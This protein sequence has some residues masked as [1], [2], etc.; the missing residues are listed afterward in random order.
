[1]LYYY[2]FSPSHNKVYDNFKFRD[3]SFTCFGV[4]N[5]LEI[6]ER[7]SMSVVMMLTLWPSMKCL[8]A[9]EFFF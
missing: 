9:K 7:N 1:M 3:F 4:V 2:M 5:F 8:T 6:N